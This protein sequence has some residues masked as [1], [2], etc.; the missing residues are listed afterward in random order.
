VTCLIFTVTTVA[1]S[2]TS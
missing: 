1:D 2:T